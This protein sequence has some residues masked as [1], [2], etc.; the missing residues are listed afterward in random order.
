MNNFHRKTKFFTAFPVFYVKVEGKRK[1][2][3]N[4]KNDKLS[5]VVFAVKTFAVFFVRSVTNFYEDEKILFLQLVDSE[6]E[7]GKKKRK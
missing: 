2:E 7:T 5:L 4:Y 6:V 1:R 3:L